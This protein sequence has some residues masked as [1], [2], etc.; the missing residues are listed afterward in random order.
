LTSLLSLMY[1]QQV[2]LDKFTFPYVWWTSF[3]WQVYFPL[4]TVNKF[5]LTNL[6]SLMY[7]QQVFLDKFT[8]L[9]VWSTSFPWQAYFPLNPLCMVNKFSLKSLFPLCTVNKFSLT[10]LLSLMYGQQ[11]FLNKFAFPYV[12]STS[13]PWQASLTQASI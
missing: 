4:C 12:R 11:V 9:Y 10:S 1:G 13:F 7:G 3:P 5:S 2:F 6:L 8:F